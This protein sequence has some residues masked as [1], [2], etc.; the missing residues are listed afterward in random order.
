MARRAS[1]REGMSGSPILGPKDS[2]AALSEHWSFLRDE[3]QSCPRIL[4]RLSGARAYAVLDLRI[5]LDCAELINRVME[6][7]YRPVITADSLQCG[8][9]QGFR[10]GLLLDL[11]HSRL[12]ELRLA[13]SS[14]VGPR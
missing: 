3:G 11:D 2:Q 4:Q 10:F 9:Q 14:S 7:R 6:R 1:V 5:L 12:N 13:C 8:G